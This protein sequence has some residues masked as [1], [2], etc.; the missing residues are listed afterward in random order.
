MTRKELAKSV[1]EKTGLSKKDAEAAVAAVF[2][3]IKEALLSGETLTIRGFGTF[4]LRYQRARKGRI[5][6]TGETVLIP[7]R[8]RVYFDPS[9]NLQAAVAEK[10]ELLDRFGGK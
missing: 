4:S 7:P 1:S 10:K 3:S 8:L 9:D 5:I 6:R 2:A